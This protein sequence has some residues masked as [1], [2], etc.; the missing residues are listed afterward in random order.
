[1]MIVKPK[2]CWS[3]IKK[4]LL[5][6]QGLL[7]ETLWYGETTNHTLHTLFPRTAIYN[8]CDQ[9]RYNLVFMRDSFQSLP[10]RS[11]CSLRTLA[12]LP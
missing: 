1:M 3:W 2:Q 12:P 4:N 7:M 6:K 11:C 8:G 10:V 5:H 9:D